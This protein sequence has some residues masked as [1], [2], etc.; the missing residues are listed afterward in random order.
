M[1]TGLRLP[2]TL[3]AGSRYPVW[4]RRFCLFNVCMEKKRLA[5]FA[6]PAG[7]I[8]VKVKSAVARDQNNSFKANWISLGSRALETWPKVGPSVILPSGT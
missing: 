4:Q 2:P 6:S 8:V 7:N 1:L 5:G 3:H